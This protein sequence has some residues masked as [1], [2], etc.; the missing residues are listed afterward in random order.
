MIM[1]KQQLI[2]ENAILKNA[3]KE[4]YKCLTTPFNENDGE[5]DYAY[6]VGCALSWIKYVQRDKEIDL[7]IIDN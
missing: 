7:G 3:L 1:K 5:N 2:D 4:A 6:R